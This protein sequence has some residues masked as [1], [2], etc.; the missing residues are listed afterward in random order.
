MTSSQ[1]PGSSESTG[2][3]AEESAPQQ[4]V[5]SALKRFRVAAVAT[6]I[7]LLVLVVVMALRYGWDNPTP[8]Q[9]WS[10]MHGALYMVYVALSVDLAIKARWSI[11]GIVLVLLAGCVPFVSFAAERTVTQRVLSGRSL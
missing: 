4:T 6:G 1:T 2:A 5:L 10:P 3:A 11:K 9:V 8:S 7:G